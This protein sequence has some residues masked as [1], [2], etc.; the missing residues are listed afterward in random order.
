MAHPLRNRNFRLLFTGRLVD[1]LGDAVS[2]A[3]LT[4][5]IVIATRS[6]AGLALVLV[7]ALLPKVALL[8]FGGVVVD[9]LGPRRV[10]M[11]AAVVSGIA[12]LFIGLLLIAGH[13]DFPLIATVA[14]VK[15]AASAFDA[16]A[17]LPLVAGTADEDGRQAA[18]SLM[19]VATSAT[20]LAGPALAG[21]LI[22]TVGAGWAFVADAAT[23]GFSA[24]TL[25]LI[26]VRPVQVPRLYRRGARAMALRDDLAAGWAEVRSRTWY[27]TSLI[28]HATW[29]FAAGMLATTGPL[30][31]VTE[32]GGKAVW[33]AALQASAAGYLIGAFIA[34][35]T[36]VNRAILVGNFALMSYAVPLVLFAI[37]AP[38][39]AVVIAYGLAMA[40]LG[41]LNPVWETAVQ[42][43]IPAQVL[44]RVSAYDWLVSLAAMP[45]GYA[46]GP[47][48]VRQFGYTWPLTATAILVL[49]SLSI[50]VS[51]PDVR[52]LQLRHDNQLPEIPARVNVATRAKEDV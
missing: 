18:N 46:L 30:I 16:P 45:L 28:G 43:E 20:N 39:W 5:A 33:L 14:A 41:F 2:P 42:Q 38:A 52:N 31:A 25:A 7:C 51:L 6:S 26:K 48:L 13:I 15:G 50:P 4:L 10:A 24:G 27:W 1:A 40:C 17:T 34:G 44:A 37:A 9:R 29:N 35:R 47:V 11:A 49:I 19:G 8:P 22:F 12:Q 32:L 3:A 36:K 23:F 21:V